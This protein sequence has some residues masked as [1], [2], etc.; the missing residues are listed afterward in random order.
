MTIKF[1]A[2]A[3]C[4]HTLYALDTYGR[5]WMRQGGWTDW[6]VLPSPMDEPA[7]TEK[8]VPA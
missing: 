8:G 5:V 4:D 3:A 1:T 6:R 7:K 2:L